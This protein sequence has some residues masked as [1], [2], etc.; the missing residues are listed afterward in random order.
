[1]IAFEVKR[2]EPKYRRQ[3]I[4]IYRAPNED[5]WAIERPAACNIPTRNSTQ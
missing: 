3:I 4:R 5:M 2:M 1:M